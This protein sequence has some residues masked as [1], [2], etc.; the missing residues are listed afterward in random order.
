MTYMWNMT[1]SDFQKNCNTHRYD[2]T[3]NPITCSHKCTYK[4][5]WRTL[6]KATV[7]G[8]WAKTELNPGPWKDIFSYHKIQQPWSWPGLKAFSLWVWSWLP[9][10]PAAISGCEHMIFLQTQLWNHQARRQ[11]NQ[12][13]NLWRICNT[14]DV[15]ATLQFLMSAFTWTLK[16]VHYYSMHPLKQKSHW[17]TQNKSTSKQSFWSK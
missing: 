16:Q 13:D 2:W 3:K 4:D 6:T 11:V 9:P 10:L 15:T 8:R 12:T 17:E 1:D 14:L 5:H 7:M